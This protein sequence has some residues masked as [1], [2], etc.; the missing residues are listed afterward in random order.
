M[1][2][3][4]RS[5]NIVISVHALAGPPY[6]IH[7]SGKSVLACTGGEPASTISAPQQ[8]AQGRAVVVVVV[9]DRLAARGERGTGTAL[10]PRERR[11]VYK[12]NSYESMINRPC[13]PLVFTRMCVYL[14]G[15]SDARD[16]E[17]MRRFAKGKTSLELGFIYF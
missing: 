8:R 4:L 13:L 16:V 17:R 3:Q 12:G 15:T 11:L 9:V 5:E 6:V 10:R 14:R 1:S 7:V 2:S